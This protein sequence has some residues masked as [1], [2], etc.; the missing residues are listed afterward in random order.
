ML[1]DEKAAKD[2]QTG[3]AGRFSSAIGCCLAPLRKWP[4][5]KAPESI[6]SKLGLPQ[7]DFQ[8][9]QSVVEEKLAN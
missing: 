3:N 7:G 5:E 8:I 4:T 2:F 6:F 1:S 9:E